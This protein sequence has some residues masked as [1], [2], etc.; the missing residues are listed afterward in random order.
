MK[1]RY[2]KPVYSEET[3]KEWAEAEK[4]AAEYHRRHSREVEKVY[5][6]NDLYIFCIA[7]TYDECLKAM[8][9]DTY[10]VSVWEDETRKDLNKCLAHKA[11]H[12]K[13]EANEYFN[14]IKTQCKF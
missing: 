12:S 13:E 11:F 8:Y 4:K 14:F 7:R 6:V 2:R 10:I 5:K 1:Y 9:E 3:Y